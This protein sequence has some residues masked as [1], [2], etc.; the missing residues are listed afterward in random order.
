MNRRRVI[1]TCIAMSVCASI[2]IGQINKEWQKYVNE[3]VTQHQQTVEACNTQLEEE[4][5]R[6]GE[7]QATM[8]ETISQLQTQKENA[9]SVLENVLSDGTWHMLEGIATAYSPFDNVSGIEA[10]ADPERTSTG[11]RPGPGIIAVDPAKIPYGSD[12][13]VIYPDGTKY[14]GTANDTGG[15]LRDNSVPHVDIYRDTYEEAEAHG[16]QDVIILWR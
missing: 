13:I 15:A 1:T 7:E 14:Y 16:V 9:E 5:T 6:W 8:Q 12:I 2:S 11:V 4:R 10:D 3:L